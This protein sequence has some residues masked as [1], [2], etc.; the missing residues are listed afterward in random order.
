MCLPPP[1]ST[2]VYKYELGFLFALEGFV[3]GRVIQ[4]CRLTTTA[5]VRSCFF[6][7]SSVLGVDSSSGGKES[8]PGRRVRRSRPM[9]TV[10]ASIFSR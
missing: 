6:F 5:Q 8:L 2:P 9:P 7:V 3:V 1:Y 4:K 10:R